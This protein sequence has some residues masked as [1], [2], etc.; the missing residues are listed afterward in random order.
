MK[1]SVIS[2]LFLTAALNAET[3]F[4]PSPD[5]II[6]LVYPDVCELSFEGSEYFNAGLIYSR[7]TAIT[8]SV[9]WKRE[10]S[11][12]IVKTHDTVMELPET[13]FKEL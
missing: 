11:K 8:T 7:V 10:N 9:C 6:V 5:G 13:L 4:M 2:L 1:K 3:L 12:I